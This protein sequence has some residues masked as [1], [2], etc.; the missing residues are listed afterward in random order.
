METGGLGRRGEG[1]AGRATRVR[2][3][4]RPREPGGESPCCE[5]DWALAK[6]A[7]T[8]AEGREDDGR[9]R[10]AEAAT[11]SSSTAVAPCA[12]MFVADAPSASSS[13]ADTASLIVRG[14]RDR[15]L[16]VCGGHGFGCRPPRLRHVCG[17]GPWP[18][19]PRWPTMVT[20]AFVRAFGQQPP[21]LWSS[22]PR[23][24]GGQPGNAS[25]VG[26]RDCSASAPAGEGSRGVHSC[27]SRPSARPRPAQ[28]SQR[29]SA[30][31]FLRDFFPAGRQPTLP[32]FAD[33][34]TGTA[35][36]RGGWRLRRPPPVPR[37]AD[38]RVAMASKTGM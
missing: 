30:A 17:S 29:H 33:I 38:D 22:S 23:R 7:T 8:R 26:W 18:R 2:A 11:A 6:P 28:T 35:L 9:L 31:L 36:V 16:L 13:S 12:S 27:P 24:R 20:T 34:L 32:R 19:P 21:R 3:S 1:P 37:R 10:D 14:G 25:A 15:R 4:R 5:E